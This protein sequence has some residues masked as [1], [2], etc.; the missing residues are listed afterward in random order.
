M[1]WPWKKYS[2]IRCVEGIRDG[3]EDIQKHLY[4]RCRSQFDLKTSRYEFI[5]EA[6]KQDL[7]QDSFVILWEKIENQQIFVEDGKVYAWKRGGRAE[8]PDLIGYFMRIVKNLYH[9]MLREKGRILEIIDEL[10]D[11][12]VLWWSDDNDI[13]RRMIITQSVL[14]LPPSCKEI[15]MMFYY[16]GLSLNEIVE[17]R[18]ENKSYDGVKN[19][20]SKCLRNLRERILARCADEGVEVPGMSYSKK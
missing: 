9:E 5:S 12:S 1:E 20:K 13:H 7:F 4:L 15:V 19:E 6:E 14:L 3:R 17:E 2:D 10:D 11:A 18:D 8:V 16:Q